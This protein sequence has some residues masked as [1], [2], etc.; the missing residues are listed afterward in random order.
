MTPVP[1][2]HGRVLEGGLL[3]LDGPSE[4]RQYLRTLAGRDVDVVVRKPRLQRSLDQNAYLHAVPIPIFADYW[5][6]E[7]ETTKLLLLGECFGW[8]ETRRGPRL[9]IKP[10]TSRLSVPEMSHFIEWLSAWG[11]TEFGLRIPLPHESEAA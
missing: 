2:F 7:I 4:Y 11:M 3:V 9:P 6:E 5:G 10:R 1:V 8:K